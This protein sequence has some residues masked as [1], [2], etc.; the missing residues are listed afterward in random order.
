MEDTGEVMRP[1][2]PWR[3]FLL[4]SLGLIL[5]VLIFLAGLLTGVSMSSSR[6]NASFRTP[7]LPGLSSSVENQTQPEDADMSVFWEA[8]NTVQSR[9][10][11]DLPSEEDRVQGAINGM[12]ETLDDPYTAYVEPDVAVI[13]NQD[14]SGS[15]E[16]IG[17]YVEEAPEGGVFII[18]VFEDGPAERAG[19]RAG[20]IVVA[21]EGEDITQESLIEN[22][23]LIRG[24][25][26]TQVT[27]TIVREGEEELLDLTVTRGRI[28]IPTA[29]WRMLESDIG[30]I[31][32]FEFN[33]RSSE[34]M[35]QAVQEL[36]DQGA[37]S[38]ILD[39]RNNPGG[40]LDQVVDIS[41]LFLDEGLI[42]IQRDV[43]GNEIEHTSDS[44]D[45]AEVI[46]LVVLING[47][48]ASASEI[49]AGAVQDRERGVLIGET[50]FGKGSVQLLLELS[51]GSQLRITYAN[52]FTPND[53]SITEQGITP[54][55]VIETLEEQPVEGAD[56]QLDR[57]IEYLQTG[58]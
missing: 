47:G 50:S 36:L 11:Y 32:L 54:D 14:N 22:L 13:L 3:S 8:W 16:G 4:A 53:H 19:I 58:S 41:D 26:G 30:Y 35:H 44:G 57:A 29:E 37:E 18:R 52:W 33:G 1:S 20:D 28:E 40:L 6:A 46:P 7:L 56:P 34:L 2:R 38:I 45:I 9:F 23:L 49:L 39:L 5:L 31:V 12:I 21:V 42:L 15:F 10:Y 48:S 24:P 27:L 43:D 55:I 17:A 25:A 51:D